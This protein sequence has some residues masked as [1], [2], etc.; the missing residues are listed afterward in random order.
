MCYHD[1]NEAWQEASLGINSH[2]RQPE[3]Q[4]PD[5]SVTRPAMDLR[6]QTLVS[7]GSTEETYAY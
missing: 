1:T 7:L 2:A 4:P 6:K 3:R 5:I